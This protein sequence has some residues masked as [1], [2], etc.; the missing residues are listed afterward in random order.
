MPH[1]FVGGN[2]SRFLFN[3]ICKIR[4]HTPFW[5]EYCICIIHLYSLVSNSERVD[6]STQFV[7]NNFEYHAYLIMIGILR[8]G[9]RSG[10][11]QGTF[12]ASFGRGAPN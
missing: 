4:Q 12:S 10:A 9:S 1:D 3:T 7:K 5:L 8:A 6:V 2:Q 11:N